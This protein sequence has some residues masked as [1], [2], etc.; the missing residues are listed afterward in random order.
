MTEV[1]WRVRTHTDTHSSNVP[2]FPVLS[3]HVYIKLVILPELLVEVNTLH[4]SRYICQSDIFCTK[5]GFQSLLASTSALSL[6]P[7]LRSQLASPQQR[8]ANRK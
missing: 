1:T 2:A 5:L 3:F 4:R 6:L 8:Q 7:K